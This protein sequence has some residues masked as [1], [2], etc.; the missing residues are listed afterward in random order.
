MQMRVNVFRVC[1][2][3]YLNTAVWRKVVLYR[4]EMPTHSTRISPKDVLSHTDNSHCWSF[5]VA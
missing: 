4:E 5:V 1:T 2:E 3:L